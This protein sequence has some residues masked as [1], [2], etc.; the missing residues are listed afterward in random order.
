MSRR[1]KAIIALQL[2]IALVLFFV[3]LVT[4]FWVVTLHGPRVTKV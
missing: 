1:S 3:A 4:P 2:L